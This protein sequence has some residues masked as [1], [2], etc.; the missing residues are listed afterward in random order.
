MFRELDDGFHGLARDRHVHEDWRR[1]DVA[2]P[3]VVMHELVVPYALTGG[4]VYA[5]ETTRIEIVAKTMTSVEI[6]RPRLDRE[7]LIVRV[8]ARV[9]NSAQVAINIDFQILDRWQWRSNQPYPMQAP[10]A[11]CSTVS[12]YGSLWAFNGSALPGHKLE[13]FAASGTPWRRGGEWG[14]EEFNIL[15]SF[16]NHPDELGWWPRGEVAP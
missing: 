16:P 14:R 5:D 15:E 1:A 8:L 9:L 7:I 4:D 11:D 10:S 6:T 13:L 12:A 3:Y 2:V